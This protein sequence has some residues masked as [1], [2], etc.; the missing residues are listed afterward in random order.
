MDLRMVKTRAQIKN[1][2]LT[3]REKMMPE[4]IKV[5][6]I[7]DVAMIN[8]T[9]FYNHYSDTF[10][11]S[12]EIDE[13]AVEKV[14]S[15]FSERDKLLEDPKAFAIGLIRVL[16]RDSAELRR[17]FRGKQ[18]V[19]CVKLEEK[20]HSL[21]GKTET[22]DDDIRLAFFMGGS[23][24]VVCD[25]IFSDIKCDKEQLTVA[26]TKMMEALASLKKNT[27]QSV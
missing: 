19:L 18:D 20:L 3:L 23:I 27:A 24:R 9:T 6:D 2:F 15:D 21:C 4:K 7:C 12:N 8:K 25:F 11:L 1:A 16:E 13:L 10:E 5:K 14:V 22:I 26:V 17:I